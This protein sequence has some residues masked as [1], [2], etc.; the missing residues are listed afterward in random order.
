MFQDNEIQSA[1]DAVLGGFDKVQT[2]TKEETGEVLRGDTMQ[3]LIAENIRKQ[4]YPELSTAP[5][6]QEATKDTNAPPTTST[7]Y[8][9]KSNNFSRVEPIESSKPPFQR[10]K[11]G[12]S[13]RRHI[14]IKGIKKSAKS[15][16]LPRKRQ[17]AERPRLM[18][19]C[20][21]VMEK[22]NMGKKHRIAVN[23]LGSIWKACPECPLES[24]RKKAMRQTTK[25]NLNENSSESPA[26]PD[27]KASVPGF[28]SDLK[29][30][31]AGLRIA[32]ITPVPR[33]GSTSQGKSRY[34]LVT[35]KAGAFL[36]PMEH[37]EPFLR[38]LMGSQQWTTPP[39]EVKQSGGS[40]GCIPHAASELEKLIV[41]GMDMKANSQ[42]VHDKSTLTGS[43]TE[44][45][46]MPGRDAAVAQQSEEATLQNASTSSRK[47]SASPTNTECMNKTTAS[48]PQ[49]QLIEAKNEPGKSDQSNTEQEDGNHM[50]STEMRIL[51]LKQRILEH[52]KEI[53]KMKVNRYRTKRR[54]RKLLYGDELS[55]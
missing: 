35:T 3:V 44:D 41:S 48:I 4:L 29:T 15:V 16:N 32:K 45:R 31:S 23:E 36:V 22:L 30:K 39:M 12:S 21:V 37:R 53:L 50:E 42:Q 13:A 33:E 2:K 34:L 26:K 55:V 8:D 19:Y 43:S 47:S 46:A 5:H 1:K 49:A 54:L 14:R 9:Q 7:H 28:L 6:L 27:I 11:F 18:N 10:K 25:P 51:K 24:K 20:H 17:R 40:T 38:K 52:Q